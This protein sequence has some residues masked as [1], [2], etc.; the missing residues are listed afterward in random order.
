MSH[1]AESFYVLDTVFTNV[2]CT[3]PH[4]TVLQ[5]LMHQTYWFALPPI[6]ICTARRKYQ[7]VCCNVCCTFIRHLSPSL[8]IATIS[9]H[10]HYLSQ[11]HHYLSS[12]SS[13]VITTAPYQTRY[14][15][16]HHHKHSSSVY[17][18]TRQPAVLYQDC[19]PSNS[20]HK[21]PTESVNRLWHG[22]WWQCGSCRR[23][24]RRRGRLTRQ[25]RLYLHVCLSVCM[26][27]C[28]GEC[29]C[30]CDVFGCAC[31]SVCL[32]TCLSLHP[33]L[34][35]IFI[36][37]VWWCIC[38]PLSDCLSQCYAPIRSTDNPIPNSQHSFC[39][40]HWHSPNHSN[41]LRLHQ[42]SFGSLCLFLFTLSHT[43]NFL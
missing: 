18:I 2:L 38:A 21:V 10:H 12:V 7:F 29:V 5:H 26:Y 14:H 20:Q 13:L 40:L 19:R 43:T 35:G 9:Q 37:W 27:V 36:P 22:Y 31:V 42:F 25:V 32:N 41:L 3:A 16:H 24:W 6:A 30:A 33:D 28:G 39:P 1:S 17:L 34:L 11:H 4:F 8:I 23:E 15:H